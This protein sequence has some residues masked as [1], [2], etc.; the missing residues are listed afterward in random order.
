M[1]ASNSAASPLVRGATLMNFAEVARSFGLNP[2][3][4]VRR[5]VS[6]LAA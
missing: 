2:I 5:G 1:P 3:S 4:L 6:I